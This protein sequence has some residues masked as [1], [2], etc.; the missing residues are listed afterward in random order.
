MTDTESQSPIKLNHQERVTLVDLARSAIMHRLTHSTAPT[1]DERSMTEA[2]KTPSGAFVSLHVEEELRGCIGSIYAEE[3]LAQ[4][5]AHMAVQAATQDPRFA[6]MQ[7]SD[8]SKTDIEVSVL[9]ELVPMVPDDVQVGVHGLLI[10]KG[11]RRGLLLPQVPGQYGWTRAEFLSQLC[12][13]AGLPDRSWTDPTCRLLM[14]T[15]DVFSDSTLFGDE[16]DDY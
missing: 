15:A 10:S 16:D 8:L 2:L 3:P 13:K 11:S 1:P 7:T 6:P 5:V 14:F 12:L 4:I 9:S